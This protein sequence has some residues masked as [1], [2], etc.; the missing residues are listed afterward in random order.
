MT[1]LFWLIDT[2]LDI[3]VFFL[4]VW[5]IMSWL[6]AFNVINTYNRFV[7]MVM[8][9]LYRIT[10]PALRPIRSFMPDLGGIDLSPLV[11]LLLIKAVQIFLLTTVA[12]ALGV[13]YY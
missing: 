10:E 3:Y 12:P 4:F 8:D 11:L 13:G 2:A 9:F 6:V 1:A 7:S 5:I